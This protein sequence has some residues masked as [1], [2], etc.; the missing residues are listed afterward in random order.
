M[1]QTQQLERHH[2]HHNRPEEDEG[3]P[4]QPLTRR[5]KD[6][7]GEDDGASQRM[8]KS[9]SSPN[10]YGHQ[11]KCNG[12]PAAHQALYMHDTD[13]DSDDDDEDE[14]NDNETDDQQNK[15]A[16]RR[17]SGS[18]LRNGNKK[19]PDGGAYAWLVCLASYITNGTIFG[20]VNCF[21]VLFLYLKE[22]FGGQDG[23]M[24]FAICK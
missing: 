22:K 4:K 19:V 15:P 18:S 5:D 14:E 10:G 11:I 9:N 3:E 16:R 21:G 1:Y 23:D 8:L 24:A 20:I 17:H 7:D 6:E 2:H 12:D 13:N